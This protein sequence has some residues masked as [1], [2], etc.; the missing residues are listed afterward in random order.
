MRVYPLLLCLKIWPAQDGGDPAVAASPRD[1]V[2][3][4]PADEA[5]AGAAPRQLAQTELRCA[6]GG[7]CACRARW[8]VCGGAHVLAG[9]SGRV[10]SAL[11]HHRARLH[12]LLTYQRWRPFVTRG[13]ALRARV[14]HHPDKRVLHYL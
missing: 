7:T 1:I 3:T 5:A 12:A 14:H 9:P 13:R 2:Y 6:R 10:M 8:R 4:L 11:L